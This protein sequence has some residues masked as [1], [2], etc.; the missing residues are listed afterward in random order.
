[1]RGLIVDPGGAPFREE[2]AQLVSTV[3]PQALWNSLGRLVIHLMSPGVPDIYQGDELWYAALV[4]PDN[5]RPVDWSERQDALASAIDTMND[6]SR[7]ATLITLREGMRAG[8]LKMLVT[9][10][11]L[12]LRA[13]LGGM[14]SADFRM[15]PLQGAR[16]RNVVAFERT[17]AS[18][19]SVIVLAPRLTAS[20]PW[21]QAGDAWQDTRLATANAMA[22]YRRVIH[23]GHCRAEGSTLRLADVFTAVPVEILVGAGPRGEPVS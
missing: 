12:A 22:T 18:G 10:A 21:P 15:L 20:L 2:M 5:R 16:A 19:T 11:L 4:D 23:G 13:E 8:E 6:E 17:L 14:Q 7:D 1:V 3:A 9:R